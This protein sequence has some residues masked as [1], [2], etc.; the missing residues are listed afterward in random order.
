M[1]SGC[2]PSDLERTFLFPFA[3]PV[4]VRILWRIDL[5]N[6]LG[7][8]LGNP[9]GSVNGGLMNYPSTDAILNRGDI[10]LPNI[11]GQEF[12]RYS[13]IRH[14]L[15]QRTSS[16]PDDFLAI[17]TFHTSINQCDYDCEYYLRAK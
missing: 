6:E 9:E 5:K 7:V 14:N 16:V 10:V 12:E 17:D 8:Y 2:P 13:K 4:A 11:R 3:N 15:K 1:V